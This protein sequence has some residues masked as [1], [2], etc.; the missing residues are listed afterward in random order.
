M[1]KVG[2]LVLLALLT[3]PRL[4]DAQTWP[5]IQQALLEPQQPNPTV[6]QSNPLIEMGITVEPAAGMSVSDYQVLIMLTTS[7]PA[8]NPN[9]VVAASTSYTPSS[10]YTE[11][12]IDTTALPVGNYWVITDLSMGSGAPLRATSQL[13]VQRST[14]PVR[15]SGLTTELSPQHRYASAD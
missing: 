3:I 11:A 15:P 9:A 6:T 14:Q 10:T 8:T 5:H 7:N 13:K 1:K 2:I 12:D 4:A